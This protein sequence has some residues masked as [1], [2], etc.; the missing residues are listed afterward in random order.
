MQT[1]IRIAL[2]GC[3]ALA[4]AACGSTDDRSTEAMPETVEMPADAALEAVV[5]EPVADDAISAPESE[6]EDPAADVAAEAA[7]VAEE[8]EQ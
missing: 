5:D 8:G 3:L 6:A 4:L 2:T 1:P 7:A